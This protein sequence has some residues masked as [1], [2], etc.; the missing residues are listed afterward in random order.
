MV[1]TGLVGLALFLWLIVAVWRTLSRASRAMAGTFTG[2]LATGTLAAL[3]A[4]L[5]QAWAAA[6]FGTIRTMEPWWFLAGLALATQR[7]ARQPKMD[8]LHP[9]VSAAEA[10]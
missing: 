6:S 4:L 10:R 8:R 7:L 9:S 2:V 1:E 5:T 3:V